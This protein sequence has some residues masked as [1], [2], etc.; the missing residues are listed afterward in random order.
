VNM[1][2]GGVGIE[3]G[4][5]FKTGVGFIV[6]GVG[7]GTGLARRTVGRASGRALALPGHIEHM[8]ISFYPS[9]CAC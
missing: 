9:S 1:C 4:C 6:A 8:A 7:V 3:R 2:S 5:T